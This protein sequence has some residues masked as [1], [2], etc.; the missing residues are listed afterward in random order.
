MNKLEL[1]EKDYLQKNIPEFRAGDTVK[2]HI[3]VQEGD[4]TRT[5]TFEGIVIKKHGRGI[6]ATFTVL[7]DMRGDIV[8]KSFPVH[9][10]SLEKIVVVKK[11]KFSRSKLYN[12]RKKKVGTA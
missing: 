4:K 7:R 1:I 12:L 11:G 5:Q 8:E 6:N 3:K 10:P 2:V 9:S